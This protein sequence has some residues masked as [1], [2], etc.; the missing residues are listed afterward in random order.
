MWGP[1]VQLL[2]YLP[3]LP[4]YEGLVAPVNYNKLGAWPLS[5]YLDKASPATSESLHPFTTSKW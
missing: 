2:K 1:F 5:T 4:S 3:C